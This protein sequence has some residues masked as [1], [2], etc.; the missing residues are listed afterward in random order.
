[1][2]NR[3][4][5]KLFILFFVFLVTRH[6]KMMIVWSH[7][8]ALSEGSGLKIMA[9]KLAED[10]GATYT[11]WSAMTTDITVFVYRKEED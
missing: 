10:G 7:F 4:N 11:A 2:Q 1:M 8:F 5:R 9:G 3:R 6:D